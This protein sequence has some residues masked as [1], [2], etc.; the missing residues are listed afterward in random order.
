[1]KIGIADRLSNTLPLVV[2]SSGSKRVHVSKVRL[3]LWVNIW[4]PVDLGRG[5]LDCEQSMT[6]RKHVTMIE[7]HMT[8]LKEASSMQ[9]SQLEQVSCPGKACLKCVE[10]IFLVMNRRRRAREVVDSVETFLH[11]RFGNRR[12]D[13][14]KVERD[15]MTVAIL[16]PSTRLQII[17]NNNRP[18]I[19]DKSAN[20]VMSDESS[21][22]RYKRTR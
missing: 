15:V 17:E 18:P 22:A 12:A 8:Y 10:R 9:F 11:K 3:R 20:Q 14:M 2:A 1:M 5:R 4:V 19:K 7:N 6:P 13:V 16:F 21:P